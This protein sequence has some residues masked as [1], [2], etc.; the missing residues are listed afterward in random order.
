MPAAIPRE[1]ALELLHS[2]VKNPNMLKHCLASEAVMRA[3]AE[4]L[5]EDEDK[6]ALAGLLHDVDV[7]ITNAD[8][9]VHCL[10]AVQILRDAGMDEE[11]IEAIRRHNE[12]AAGVPRETPFQHAL[13]AGETITGLIIATTLVYPDRKLAS[14]KPKSITKR[15]KEKAFAASVSRENIREC[16]LIGIPL[17]EFA[18][19]CLAAMCTI[20]DYLGL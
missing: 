17:P 2:Y 11:S 15:M 8:L 13:A 1:K 14:V 19:I 16:E 10:E 4:R 6:W 20:S 18:A 3:I 5:G 7:E 9:N 12:V